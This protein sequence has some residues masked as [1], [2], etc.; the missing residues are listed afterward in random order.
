MS[1]SFLVSSSVVELSFSSQNVPPRTVT[2]RL[3]QG[4]FHERNRVFLN[5]KWDNEV[6]ESAG[7]NMYYILLNC[8]SQNNINNIDLLYNAR[9]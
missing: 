7:R 9:K 8:L 5:V 1:C 4:S 2:D 6:I 3:H